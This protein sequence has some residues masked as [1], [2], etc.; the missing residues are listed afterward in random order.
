MNLEDLRMRLVFRY[1]KC[2]GFIYIPVH[3]SWFLFGPW[4]N[5]LRN[6]KLHWFPLFQRKRFLLLWVWLLSS[7]YGKNFDILKRCWV[8]T[9]GPLVSQS[10]IIQEKKEC[11]EKVNS[12]EESTKQKLMTHKSYTISVKYILSTVTS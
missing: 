7:T 4:L 8:R 5:T 6:T 2:T 3:K 1:F 12:F 9:L 10:D 11:L